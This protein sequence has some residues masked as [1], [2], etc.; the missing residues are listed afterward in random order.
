MQITDPI[1]NPRLVIEKIRADTLQQLRPGQTLS[2]RVESPLER[3]VIQLNIGGSRLPVKSGLDLPVGTQINLQVVKSGAQPEFQLIRSAPED[4]T[5]ALALKQILPR[6]LP[7]RQLLESLAQLSPPSLQAQLATDTA[8]G[9]GQAAGMDKLPPIIQQLLQLGGIT[10][11]RAGGSSGPEQAL[12]ER[13]MQSLAQALQGGS[14]ATSST[15]EL[16]GARLARHINAVINSAISNDRPLSAAVIRQALDNSGLFLEARLGGEGTVAPD[17]KVHLLKLLQS[18][19]PAS[20]G[21]PL[22]ASTPSGQN[23]D[24]G[25]TLQLLAARL[26]AELK[27]AAEGALA[28]V[29][30]H[31]LASLP[32]ED[33]SLRQV[34]QFELPIRHPEGNDE[35]LIRFEKESG[36]QDQSSDRWSVTLDFNIP[37][38]GPMSVRLS[39]VDGVLSSHFT[40][41]KVESVEQ[42]ERFLP[43]LNDALTSAGLNVGKLSTRLGSV[44]SGPERPSTTPPLLDERA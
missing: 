40:A 9:R 41:E 44:G 34:W 43:R 15:R 10:P 3:G 32:Q 19:L 17:L 22:P 35:F 42:I 30:M 28:R 14:G 29:Q 5:R 37:P 6:Q 24:T 23:M 26:F 27:G 18:L 8:T 21:H 11:Q 1:N 25:T 31:Q 2:A 12:L 39:L 20:S 33:N 16:D 4:Q 38:A 36:R 7:I 13:N